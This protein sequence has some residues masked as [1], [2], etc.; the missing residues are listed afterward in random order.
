MEFEFVDASFGLDQWFENRTGPAGP[1]GGV[2]GPVRLIGP[3]WNRIGIG[4]PEPAVQPM[5]RMNRPVLSEPAGS[6][7]INFF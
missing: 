5:N 6:I 7:K 4:P 1:T 3:G 2:S